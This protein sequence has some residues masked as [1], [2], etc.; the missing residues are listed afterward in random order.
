MTEF[1]VDINAST[2]SA[3]RLTFEQDSSTVIFTGL[4][5]PNVE[6]IDLSCFSTG[7]TE[8][9]HNTIADGVVRFC[10]PIPGPQ[11]AQWVDSSYD[12]GVF[13]ASK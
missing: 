13:A 5:T 7:R 12:V 11:A 3:N 2:P 1:L 6:V 9:S 8:C 10:A 4:G